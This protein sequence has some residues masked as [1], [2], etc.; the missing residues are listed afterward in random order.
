MIVRHLFV[1]LAPVLLSGCVTTY[2]R[3]AETF[4]NEPET[5]AEVTQTTSRYTIRSYV[6]KF[7]YVINGR[8]SVQSSEVPD[9]AKKYQGM[10]EKLYPNIY[11][12]G[13]IPVDIEAVYFFDSLDSG[14]RS[15]GSSETVIY[16]FSVNG[17]RCPYLRTLRASA[18]ARMGTIDENDDYQKAFAE[19]QPLSSRHHWRMHYERV[20]WPN[21]TGIPG[22]KNEGEVLPGSYT[23]GKPE[24]EAFR[25]FLQALARRLKA[26]E[27]PQVTIK[28][29]AVMKPRADYTVKR[30]E[31]VAG[32]GT[33]YEFDIEYAEGAD[34]SDF[35]KNQ[36]SIRDLVQTDFAE[37]NGADKHDVH[38]MFSSF[39]WDDNKLA[40]RAE[41]F[42]IEAPPYQYDSYTRRGKLSARV[43]NGDFGKARKWAIKH[44]EAIARSKN[45]LLITGEEPPPGKYK[46][47]NERVREDNTLEIE[48]EVE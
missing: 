4:V 48:F 34:I 24:A 20:T 5:S 38:V 47:L 27:N 15:G 22:T 45:I 32:S 11:G 37:A 25:P 10:A 23:Y 9:G 33:A 6:M 43:V 2:S 36:A 14:F 39:K 18:F 16:N 41:V 17:K 1:L 42:E 7:T 28:K 30:F 19:I 31:K 40:G 12:R 44:V 26:L 35:K 29:A 3:Y 46:L 21:G 8:L 13:G